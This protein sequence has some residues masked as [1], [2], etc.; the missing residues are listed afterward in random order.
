MTNFTFCRGR[1]H[2]TTT[3]FSFSWTLI[4]LQN[5]TAKKVAHIWQIKRDGISA[6]KFEAARIHFLTDV[7]V[8]VAVIFAQASYWQPWVPGGRVE[9]S[10]A[11]SSYLGETNFSKISLQ[12]LANCF[13]EKQNGSAGRGT[14]LVGSPFCDA[15]VTLKQ[16][17]SPRSPPSMRD[18][19]S[20][21]ERF[22]L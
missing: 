11:Y 16:F 22:L 21:R 12:N 6:I 2:T 9:G 15:M 17:G 10:P 4:V 8:A 19:Q 5:S 13:H 3:F 18:N 20:M 1:E 7:F 14:L